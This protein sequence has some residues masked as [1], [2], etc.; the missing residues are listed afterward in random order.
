MTG[1]LLLLAIEAKDWRVEEMLF[2]MFLILAYICSG[3][4]YDLVSILFLNDQNRVVRI[5]IPVVLLLGVHTGRYY[6]IPVGRL[7]DK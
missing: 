5:L 3:A 6:R 1:N 7:F 4:A 2:T